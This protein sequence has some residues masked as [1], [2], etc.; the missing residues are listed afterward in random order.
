MTETC[1][2]G[3]PPL[4]VHVA[5]TP[6]PVVDRAVLDPLHTALAAK[7]LLPVRHLIDAAYIGADGLVIAARDHG[8]ALTVF[9]RATLALTHSR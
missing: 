3:R 6:A 4:I 7:D 1:D 8:V 2:D 9:R 5:T